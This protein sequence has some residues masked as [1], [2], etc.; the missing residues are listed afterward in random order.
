MHASGI[1]T[2]AFFFFQL[3]FAVTAA[4][5]VSG[6]VAERTKLASYMIFAVLLT[7]VIYPVV[8]HWIWGGGWLA[9]KGF[10]DFAGST[11]V[12]SI[13]GWAALVGAIVAGPRL[14]KYA[15][16]GKVKPIP[17]HNLAMVTL[18]GL[19]LWVGWYGFNAGS[20][21]SADPMK[22]AHICL[23][24][25]LGAGFGAGIAAIWAWVR[26]GKPD[27]SLIVNGALA[28]LVGITAGC[29][30]VEP[31]AA[32][33][34][35]TACGVAVIEAVMFFDKVK[36]DDPVGATSVHLVCGV[37]GTLFVG[38]FGKAALGLANDGLVYG[39]GATQLWIQLQGVL[40]TAVFVVAVSIVCWFVIKKTIGVR[41]SE[42]EEIAGLDV[43]EIGVEAYPVDRESASKIVS[44]AAEAAPEMQ[45]ALAP[46]KA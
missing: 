29:A 28:G 26:V 31:W 43:A 33:V 35:G 42:D 19:I 40:A 16:D 39:G 12:H 4:T 21:L 7:A 27:L 10:A 38:V 41:V 9:K 45:P 25:T 1:P 22:I 6:A 17:G 46:S 36:V 24:T 11:V 2:A 20:Q 14:G 3:C 15:K 30:F 8:G 37:L 34:I 13:G 32:A 44:A 18:G 23:T 5:I